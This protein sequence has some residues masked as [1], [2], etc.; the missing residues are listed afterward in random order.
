MK[1]VCRHVGVCCVACIGDLTPDL[2]SFDPF[3][4]PSS[5]MSGL[6]EA[7]TRLQTVYFPIL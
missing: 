6:N 3:P 2:S 5:K 7:R 4:G 1:N